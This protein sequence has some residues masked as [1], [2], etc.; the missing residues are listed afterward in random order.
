MEEEKQ[1]QIQVKLHY[2]AS[3]KYTYETSLERLNLDEERIKDISTGNGFVITSA[4]PIKDDIKD[5]NGVFSNLYGRTLD[6]VA[7]FSDKYRCRCGYLKSKFNEHNVC[8]I[9]HTTV[10]HVGEN[11]SYF[12]Y[13]VLSN[14]YWV[15]HPTLYMSLQSFIGTEE[16]NNILVFQSQKDEDGNDIVGKVN[17][18]EPFF[19]I[20]MME[21]HDRFDEIM[22]YYKNKF[23]TQNKLERYDD[24][25]SER[26][27]VF[28][29]SIPVY[30]T[31]LRPF[32]A[33]GGELHYESTNAIY[34]IMSS[35][36]VRINNDGL[37]MNK[38]KK[39]KNELLYDLQMKIKELFTEIQKIISG[40]KGSV[41]SLMGGRFNFSARSVIGP[42]KSLK[43]DEVLLSYQLLCSIMQQQIINLLSR[44]K[45]WHYNQAYI[46]LDSHRRYEDPFIKEII[47]SII[48]SYPRGIPVLINRNPTITYGGILQMYCVGLCSAHMLKLPVFILRLMAADSHQSPM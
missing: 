38:N 20:G 46:Y 9:C 47:L 25:M 3:D 42:D 33:S 35:I 44:L 34:K 37:K 6:D 32:Q 28:T 10:E 18:K 8:P 14:S 48:N 21:F 24:I 11:F 39:S 1:A 31:L 40:K 19:G 15:I 12:G 7:P 30:T 29:H 4:K 45:G 22:E 26:D 23:K 43:Y 13:L 27:K 36:V 5:P 16:F 2:P 17:K 41:R